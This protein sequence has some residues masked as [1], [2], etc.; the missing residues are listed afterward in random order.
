MIKDVILVI[1]KVENMVLDDNLWFYSNE[2]KLSSRIL[3]GHQTARP[4]IVDISGKC[5]GSIIG[6]KH[7]LSAAHC[8]DD[9]DGEGNYQVEYRKRFVFTIGFLDLRNPSRNSKTIFRKKI[10]GIAVSGSNKNVKKVITFPVWNV[11][12]SGS[13]HIG[14]IIPPKPDYQIF[15]NLIDIALITLTDDIVF[16]PHSIEKAILGPPNNYNNNCESCTGNC[17]I[18]KRFTALGLGQMDIGMYNKMFLINFKL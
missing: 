5:T 16:V 3:H 11:K 17:D 4:Y 13:H 10:E 8:F 15:E 2:E 14:W 9:N 18:S 6:K 7:V 12:H 1:K